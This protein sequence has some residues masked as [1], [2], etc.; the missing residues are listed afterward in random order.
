LAEAAGV[1]AIADYQRHP[2]T[3]A[4]I[5][6]L[7]P[8]TRMELSAPM[9]TLCIDGGRKDKIRPGDILGALTSAAGIAAK[10]VGKIDISDNCAYVAIERG[11]ANQAV[12]QLADGTIKGR[13]LKVWKVR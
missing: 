10:Y 6:S 5:N 8:E 3:L 1:N 11:M 9:T 12:R 7:Q 13:K 2:V 4:A